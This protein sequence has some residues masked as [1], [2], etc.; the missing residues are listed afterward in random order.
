M[1]AQVEHDDDIPVGRVLHRREMLA[2]LAGA[3]GLLLAGC[4]ADSTSQTGS[5][6]AA[7]QAVATATSQ[8]TTAAATTQ[9]ATTAAT[10]TTQAATAAATTAAQTTQAATTTTA[11]TA[12]TT[13]AQTTAAVTSVAQLS[14]VVVPALTEGPYFVDE[15]LN[16]TDI[17]T[18]PT[19]GTVKEGA[20]LKLT[21]NVSGVGSSGGCTPY[22]G[23]YVDVWHCDGVGVYSDV[24]DNAQGFATVGKKFL[25]GY[26]VTDANGKAEF[27]TIYP[28]WYQGRTV[29]IHFK[30][31]NALGATQAH[32]FTSQLFFDDT[33]SDG[34]F[35]AAPYNTN[36]QRRI[37]NASDGIYQQGGTALVLNVK[38]EGSIYTASFNLGVK[39]A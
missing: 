8:P 28:G 3:G 12:K 24:T 38:K 37:K 32:T 33:F 26:Q 21:F 13:A 14:C 19:D 17:R 20:T 34:V 30:I 22:A 31:R 9:A 18:D 2:L 16:R 15:R 36:K 7:T 1:K 10:Q 39:I 29:H 35:A 27:T 4:G 25:R 5:G 23:A 11:T 6:S